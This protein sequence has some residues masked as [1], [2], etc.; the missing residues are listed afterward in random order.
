MKRHIVYIDSI[1]HTFLKHNIWEKDRITGRFDFK[2]YDVGIALKNGILYFCKWDSVKRQDLKST[3]RYLKVPY[4]EYYNEII[5]IT[6][7]EDFL[8]ISYLKHK[9]AFS[10]KLNN[11]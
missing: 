3:K 11:N 1:L 9:N 6:L 10:R 2:C 7:Y 4:S 5:E 8:K